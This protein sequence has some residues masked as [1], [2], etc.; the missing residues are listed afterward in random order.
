MSVDKTGA[1]VKSL[2]LDGLRANFAM[3]KELGA[4]CMNDAPYFST[5]ANPDE[6]IYVIW[7]APHMMKLARGCFKYHNLYYHGKPMHWDFIVNL[8]EMQRERNINL[9]NKLTNMHL[10]FHVKPMNVRL[11]AETLSKSVA[12]CIDQL[13]ED[14]YEK[15]QDSQTTTEYIRNID[16]T[17]NIL[18]F[19]PNIKGAGNDFINP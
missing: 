14:G 12:Q 6:K 1:V 8:H 15:F 3:I 13:R 10:D 16:K 2:T 18:N 17:F 9:G 11:A 19:K 4:N 5:P 7:D